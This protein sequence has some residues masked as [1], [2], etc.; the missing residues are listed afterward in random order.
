MALIARTVVSRF[1]SR[2]AAFM[3]LADDRFR[4]PLSIVNGV[5]SGVLPAE[6]LSVWKYVVETQ[7]SHAKYGDAVEHWRN[8]CKKMSIALPAE[9]SE[10][11]SLGGEG[12]Q[13]PWKVKTGEQVEDWVKECLKS[14]GLIEEVG[15][16]VYEWKLQINH[17]EREVNDAQ[18]LVDK[19]LAGISEGNR[20][21]QRQQWLEKAKK[22]LDEN[23]KELDRCKEACDELEKQLAR[24][25]EHK[26]PTVE[27][28][29]EFQ[30]M[31]G[32]AAKDFSNKQ[33]LEAVAKALERFE[34]GL[35]MPGAGP[36]DDPAMYGGYKAAGI[37]DAVLGLLEKAW[38]FVKSAFKDL[39]DWV[40]DLTADTKKLEGLLDKAGA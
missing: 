40:K 38:D 33:V 13:G 21:K 4:P 23:K 9:Y 29:K 26:S 28:E 5:D 27:F 22:S 14:K 24:Y 25:A 36:Q 18:G 7:G 31:L 15:R 8:K 19:H 17:Y 11:G 10:K 37:G 6:V 1:L 2:E 16:S 35:P 39:A 12:S 20:V 30:F 3:A 32:I 34:K